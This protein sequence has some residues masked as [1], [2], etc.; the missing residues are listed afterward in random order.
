MPKAVVSAS[1]QASISG[2]THA[3]TT[4]I[5]LMLRISKRWLKPAMGELR[6]VEQPE[7]E[8]RIFEMST[9]LPSA[10]RIVAL[11]AS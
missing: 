10:S 3:L 11:P 9:T 8:W 5:G 1:P 7:I 6:H 4:R 2:V